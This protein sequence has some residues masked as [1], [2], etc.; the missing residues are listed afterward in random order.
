M[1]MYERIHIKTMVPMYIKDH[2]DPPPEHRIT[3]TFVNKGFPSSHYV[4]Q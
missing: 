3:L 1:I 4:Y 2:G